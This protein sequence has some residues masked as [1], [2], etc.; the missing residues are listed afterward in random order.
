MN[1]LRE[2]AGKSIQIHPNPRISSLKC[3]QFETTTPLDKVLRQSHNQKTSAHR[4]GHKYKS[5][6]T[7][8]STNG[9]PISTLHR[10]KT[11]TMPI[12][13][14]PSLGKPVF[15]HVP[16]SLCTTQRWHGNRSTKPSDEAK[17][18]AGHGKLIGTHLGIE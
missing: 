5:S 18:V 15:F 13:T 6:E 3:L 1:A 17:S 10:L 9:S 8:Q 11:H 14:I 16:L 7:S 12:F 4:P 2:K